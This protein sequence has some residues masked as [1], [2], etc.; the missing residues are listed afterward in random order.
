[1]RLR[2]CLRLH[3][4]R[5]NIAHRYLSQYSILLPPSRTPLVSHCIK[6]RSQSSAWS[7]ENIYRVV[8]DSWRR[9]A[10][11][12][13]SAL[14]LKLWAK[15]DVDWWASVAM[16]VEVEARDNH[17]IV[18]FWAWCMSAECAYTYSS[19]SIVHL[20]MPFCQ[21][22]PI[23][24]FLDGEP[25]WLSHSYT[26]CFDPRNGT[27]CWWGHCCRDDFCFLQFDYREFLICS[28]G[29]LL[30]CYRDEWCVACVVFRLLWKRG[31]RCFTIH[32]YK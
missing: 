13:C 14:A 26:H 19:K 9:E 21:A 29:F 18:H 1:M 30:R 11:Y 10:I 12:R 2:G 5:S 15:W 27:P 31:Y 6:T 3:R 22:N 17:S 24:I 32:C 7:Q 28:F 8:W 25:K 23:T 4:Q 16:G 20:L